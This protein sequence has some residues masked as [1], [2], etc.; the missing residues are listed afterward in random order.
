MTYTMSSGT[1]NPSIWGRVKCELR[2][3]EWVFCELKCEL[4]SNWS[5]IFRTT[6]TL[7]SAN[8]IA[9]STNLRIGNKTCILCVLCVCLAT[10]YMIINYA[11]ITATLNVKKNTCT[12]SV[13]VVVHIFTALWIHGFTRICKSNLFSIV[14]SPS[15]SSVGLLRGYPYVFLSRSGYRPFITPPPALGN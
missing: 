7:P 8:A 6:R 14:T 12:L 1:L 10:Y 9:H 4:A 15:R 5:A 13:V 2:N 3:C 11:T